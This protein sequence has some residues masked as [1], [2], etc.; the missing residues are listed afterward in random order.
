M[1]KEIFNKDRDKKM[2]FWPRLINEASV[3][4]LSMT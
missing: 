3:V 4:N 2:S 1:L